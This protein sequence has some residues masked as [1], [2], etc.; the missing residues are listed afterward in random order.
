MIDK[1]LATLAERR[2]LWL[3]D[4]LTRTAL[5]ANL[6]EQPR[7]IRSPRFCSPVPPELPAFPNGTLYRTR[8]DQNP[9]EGFASRRNWC[10]TECAQGEATVPCQIRNE[11]QVFPCWQKNFRLRA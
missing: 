1:A 10:I 7:R 9:R 4:D 6:I 5:I 11:A 3:G 2:G 8:A